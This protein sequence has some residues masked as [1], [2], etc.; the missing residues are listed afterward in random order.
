MGS[1][2]RIFSP[3]KKPKLPRSIIDQPMRQAKA[4]AAEDEKRKKIA[5][6]LAQ[7]ATGAGGILSE[8]NTSRKKLLGN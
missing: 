5:F 3:P 4:K 7:I 6:K 8:A 1:V 2:T